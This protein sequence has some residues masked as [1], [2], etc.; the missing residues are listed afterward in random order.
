MHLLRGQAPQWQHFPAQL[1]EGLV[2]ARHLEIIRRWPD[3]LRSQAGVVQLHR[4]PG[5]CPVGMRLQH[6]CAGVPV[7]K[8]VVAVEN[9][10]G[11]A[12][13]EVA[14]VKDSID[15][16]RGIARCHAA[17]QDA[18]H[19]EFVNRTVAAPLITVRLQSQE[20]T[21]KSAL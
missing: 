3:G 10:I 11:P 12:V 1:L 14:E 7:A 5:R 2:G 18:V 19:A 20:I 13:P 15:H 6:S 4:Y 9:I 17:R 21:R 8:W 16:R